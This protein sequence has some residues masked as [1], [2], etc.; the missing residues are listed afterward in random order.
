MY[1]MST[2]LA[3]MEIGNIALLVG[4]GINLPDRIS[5]ALEFKLMQATLLSVVF[6]L[7]LLASNRNI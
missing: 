3:T 1:L 6:S 5:V 2:L 7:P 4:H